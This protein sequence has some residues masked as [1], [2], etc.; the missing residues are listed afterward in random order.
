MALIQALFSVV[1]VTFF[2]GKYIFRVFV[3]IG[4]F[5]EFFFVQSVL[6]LQEKNKLFS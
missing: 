4:N 5:C 1:D 3:N 6:L 2:I